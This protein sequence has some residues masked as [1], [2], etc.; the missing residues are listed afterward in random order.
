M[1]LVGFIIRIYHDD[2]HLNVKYCNQTFEM[3]SKS[4]FSFSVKKLVTGNRAHKPKS[5]CF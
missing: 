3:N 1:H 5:K 2:C 4:K